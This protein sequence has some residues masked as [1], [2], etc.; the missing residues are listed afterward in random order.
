[1]PRIV[2]QDWV[3]REYKVGTDG[4]YRIIDVYRGAFHIEVLKPSS[5]APRVALITG[6]P[7]T[8][9]TPGSTFQTASTS[10]VMSS[11]LATEKEEAKKRRHYCG[12]CGEKKAQTDDYLCESCRSSAIAF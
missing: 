5:V 7:F 3:G 6:E 9:Y 11:V 12:N 8:Q 4:R 1:M 10:R 2:K